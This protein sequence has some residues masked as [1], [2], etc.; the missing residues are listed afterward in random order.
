VRMPAAWNRYGESSGNLGEDWPRA[1]AHEL[2][3]FV[4]FLDDDYLGLDAS[5][6]LIPVDTCPSAMSDPYRGDKALGYGEFHLNV[7]W[8]PG[9]QDTLA[10]KTVG[11]ADWDTIH[12]AYPWLT[13]TLT[14]TGPSV[15]PLEVTQ[16]REAPS[17]A[18]TTTLDVPIFYLY[19]PGAGRVQPGPHARAF[20]FQ[21]DQL[22]DLGRA[23]LDQVVARGARPGDRLCLV[24]PDAA[25][26]HGAQS[27]CTVITPGDSQLPLY[28][29]PG[30][31]P[32]VI[33]TPVTSRTVVISVTAAGLTQT[34]LARLYPA[35]SGATGVL[36]LTQMITGTYS[37][38]FHLEWPAVAAYVHVWVDEGEPRRETVTDYALGGNPAN[39]GSRD[40]NLGSRDANLGSRDANLGSRDANLGSRD[41]PGMSTDGQ[42]M[43]FGSTLVFTPGAFVS[44]QAVTVLPQPPPWATLV[45]QGYRLLK[46]SDAPSLSGTSIR[47]QYAGRDVPPGE[48]P[49]L[50]LYYWDGAAW[51]RLETRLDTY[52]NTA[53]AATPGEGLYALMSSLE[54]PLYQSGW[55]LI[56]YPVQGTRSVSEALASIQDYATVAYGQVMT[57]T[58]NPWKVYGPSAPD[59]VSDLKVLEFGHGYWIH[60]TDAITLYLKGGSVSSVQSVSGLTL[61]PAT[62]YGAV[63][64]GPGFTPTVGMTVTA[65]VDGPACGQTQ[66]QTQTLEGQPRLV[67]VLKVMA[68]DGSQSDGCGAPGRKLQLQVG[69]QRMA[70]DATWDNTQVTRWELD[71]GVNLPQ[72][73]YLPLVLR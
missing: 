23:T 66:V 46:L 38:T 65:W 39:L 48:E 3:H 15:L 11:R 19:A 13:A 10:N 60:V 20:L 70:T 64:H 50:R 57:D 2:G 25:P 61:P 52:Y 32:E 71:P 73:V 43:L 26:L 14:N 68:D 4:F 33:V 1:L 16:I 44:L 29:H 17:D 37:G 49:F 22:I 18:L 21:P 27:G 56:S 36:T 5:G 9:C 45:G 58:S 47:F 59:W 7:G 51:H 40:A 54:I 6:L 55:N 67:Y 69:G 31:R 12:A 53:V 8:L 63:L 30:W 62:F 42:A 24:D 41:A 34:L 28:A 72:R 35:N